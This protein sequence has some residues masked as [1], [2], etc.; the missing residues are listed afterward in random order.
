MNEEKRIAT[1][2]DY[3]KENLIYN[4]N[5][6]NQHLS[7]ELE[8]LQKDKKDS[9]ITSRVVEL[10]F[11]TALLSNLAYRDLSDSDT[12]IKNTMSERN[13]DKGDHCIVN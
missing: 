2:K 8:S 4:A 9:R 13:L 10:A 7:D 5:Q 1:P 3:L 11:A 6:L 12:V